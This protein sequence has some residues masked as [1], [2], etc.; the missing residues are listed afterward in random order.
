MSQT[1]RHFVLTGLS[2]AG[3]YLTGCA[4]RSYEDGE[5]YHSADWRQQYNGRRP[6][7]AYVPP[8]ADPTPHYTPPPSAART[9]S[10]PTPDQGAIRA[11]PRE[12]W[13]GAGVIPQRLNRMGGISRITIHHEGWTPVYFNDVRSTSKRLESIRR[14]HLQRMGAGDIGYHLVIDR[15]GRVWQGRDLNYQGAHVREAN[16]HNIGIMVLGNFEKQQPTKAQLTML[17]PTIIT[18]QQAYRVPRSKV[19][20][21]RELGRTSCPGRNL[22][23]PM[24]AL[25]RGR[26]GGLA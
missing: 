26:L 15:A 12:Y 22:Q 8:P 20:T 6:A 4:A 14:S 25:R 13:A 17:R 9:P 10:R 11:I 19:Y 16:E 5:G 3:L 2:A 7:S 23:G 1:R 24:V 18:L 21:H